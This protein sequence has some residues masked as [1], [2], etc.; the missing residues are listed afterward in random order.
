[1]SR[2][3]G[4]DTGPEVVLRKALWQKGLR[5]RISYPLPGRPDLVFVAARLA[6]FVDGCFWHG[7]PI[8][9][10]APENNSQFW[11]RKIER[12]IERDREVEDSLTS[13]GWQVLRLWEHEV[14]TDTSACV[15]R[16]A[17][18]LAHKGN[19]KPI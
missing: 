9:Y 1:M 14:R 17:V 12:T 2:N 4:R 7:C 5:Y 16:I 19:S 13:V 10:Q 11:K 3:R 18:R 8:H 6:I 15:E